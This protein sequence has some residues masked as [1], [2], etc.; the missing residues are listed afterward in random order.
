MPTVA[1]QLRGARERQ[2]RSVHQVADQT[3]M[4]TEHVRAL[5][6]GRYDDFAAAVY[7]RGFVRSYAGVLGLPVADIMRDLEA[8]L[9][10]TKRFKDLPS[11]TGIAQGPLDRLMLLASRVNWHLAAPVLVIVALTAGGFWLSR[12]WHQR[13]AQDPLAGMGP[14]LY[15]PSPAVTMELL[16]LTN[17]PAPAAVVTPQAPPRK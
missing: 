4:R 14:G 5:E 15:Q 12:I 17:A 2:K 10:Q 9:S 8:E 16:P 11:L 13:Q 6:E 7:I 3:K 1:E